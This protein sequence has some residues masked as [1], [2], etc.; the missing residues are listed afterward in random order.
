M[1]GYVYLIRSGEFVKIGVACNVAQRLRTLQIA[2]ATPLV[3]LGLAECEDPYGTEK[4]IHVR[5]AAK[6]MRGEWFD[7]PDHDLGELMIDY[8]FIAPLMRPC[9]PVRPIKATSW[10]RIFGNSVV[11]ATKQADRVYLRLRSWTKGGGYKFHGYLGALQS[12]RSTYNGQTTKVVNDGHKADY[13]SKR[14][15]RGGRRTGA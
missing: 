9:L 2:H 15:K 6:H 10:L 8:G 12:R 1:S 13:E 5:L 3:L 14:G 4:K 11:N 7:L